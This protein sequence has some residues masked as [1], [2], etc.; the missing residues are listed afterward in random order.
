M[1]IMSSDYVIKATSDG[2]RATKKTVSM[3]SVLLLLLLSL[4]QLTGQ[5]Q[6]PAARATHCA[7]NGVIRC[8][9]RPSQ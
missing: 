3:R 5:L 4:C 6:L 1:V 9:V 8:K 2:D 7:A